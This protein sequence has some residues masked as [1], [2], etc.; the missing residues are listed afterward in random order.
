MYLR[1]TARHPSRDV[2]AVAGVWPLDPAVWREIQ[3]GH[4]TRQDETGGQHT[5][6]DHGG[7]RLR[8]L[9]H[10]IYRSTVTPCLA[11]TTNFSIT[12]P[13]DLVEALIT[14][15]TGNL[16]DVKSTKQ[17]SDTGTLCR[18]HGLIQQTQ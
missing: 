18:E 14:A 10:P 5:Q 9:S 13:G 1:T 6:I 16:D 3:P 15:A 12:F 7:Y 8:S 17:H 2:A 4:R 11:E